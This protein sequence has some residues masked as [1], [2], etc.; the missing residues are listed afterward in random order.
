MTTTNQS[1]L[2]INWR[3]LKVVR[4]RGS[5]WVNRTKIRWAQT[6]GLIQRISRLRWT[7]NNSSTTN[8]KISWN[9]SMKTIMTALL[10]TSNQL[11]LWKIRRRMDTLS[12]NLRKRTINHLRKANEMEAH[13]SPKRK[14]VTIFQ[15]PISHM[16]IHRIETRS[17]RNVKPVKER[18]HHPT[19]IKS[20]TKMTLFQKGIIWCLGEMK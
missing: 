11:L 20:L 9:K 17:K 5:S 1:K 15:K 16:L 2:R 19:R 12:F 18:T 3:T 7:S 14:W 4:S 10:T 13:W 6:E 8:D